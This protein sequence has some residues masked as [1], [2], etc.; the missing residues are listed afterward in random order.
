MN[1]STSFLAVNTLFCAITLFCS[2]TPS[3]TLGRPE[4]FWHK[5]KDYFS[6]TVI[7][8][9]FTLTYPESQRESW[10]TGLVAEPIATITNAGFLATAYKHRKTAPLSSA[11]LATAGIVSAISHAVPYHIFNIADKIAATSSVAAVI[12]DTKL[13]KPDIL[14]KT[15]KDPLAASLLAGSILSYVVDI[16][17]PRSG[18]PR[19]E[20]YSY[21]HGVWHILAALLANTALDLNPPIGN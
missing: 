2:E 18:L 17:L 5:V 20:E 4:G 12:Y 10:G 13:Y 8:P 6:A 19:K 15:L 14:K 9:L 7:A 16:Y 3:N 1:K 11:A 21:I